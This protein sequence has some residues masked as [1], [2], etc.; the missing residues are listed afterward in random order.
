MIQGITKAFAR[1]L[2]SVNKDA[3]IGMRY[4]RSQGDPV[5]EADAA[6]VLI[7]EGAD[8]LSTAYR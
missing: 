8:V 4:G 5:K 7:A 2:R 6:K 3:T 1:G